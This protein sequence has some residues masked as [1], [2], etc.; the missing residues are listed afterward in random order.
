M[1]N[2]VIT[3]GEEAFVVI[4]KHTRSLA[5]HVDKDSSPLRNLICSFLENDQELY[6]AV[7]AP[8]DDPQWLARRVVSFLGAYMRIND[9]PS[10]EREM[11]RH[12]ESCLYKASFQ[13]SRHSPLATPSSVQE[14]IR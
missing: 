5:M 4:S 2:P 12:I 6:A 11:L 8:N 1:K 9:T 10:M 3:V 13:A 7:I 14:P